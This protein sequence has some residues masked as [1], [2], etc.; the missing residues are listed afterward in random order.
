MERITDRQRRYIFVLVRNYADLTKYTSEEAREVLTI[1]YCH[2]NS[3]PLFSLSD[4][5]L[6]RASD[7][8]QF[9]L[10]YTAEWGK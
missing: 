2:E 6:E 9:I 8:I 10:R 4:C 1:I 5:S 3:I 7:F